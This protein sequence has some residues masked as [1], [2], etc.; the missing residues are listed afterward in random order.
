MRKLFLLSLMLGGVLAQAA[1]ISQP[2]ALELA[3]NFINQNTARRMMS[4][5]GSSSQLSLAHTAIDMTGNVDIYIFNRSNEGGFILVAGDDQLEPVLGFSDRGSFDANNMPDGLRYWL[6]EYQRQMEYL[7]ANPDKVAPRKASS[8]KRNAA[9]LLSTCWNQSE[10]YNNMCPTYTSEGETYHSVTG[11]VATAAAQIMK[12]WK[13]P[14][15]GKGS[16]VYSCNVNNSGESLLSAVFSKSTYRWDLMDNVY[17][18]NS[19]SSHNDAVALLMRD[20]GYAS[21]MKYGSSSGTSNDKIVNA[22]VN[23]FGYDSGI[24]LEIRDYYGV[25]AWEQMIIDEIDASRPVYYSGSSSKG[26][27]AFVVDGY[28]T[29]GYF[30]INWGWGGSSDGYF[31]TS[32][33]NPKDQGIGSFEGGYN[34][35]QAIIINIKPDEGGKPLVRPLTGVCRI[36]PLLESVPL[37]TQAQFYVSNVGI[38]GSKEWNNYLYWG[39]A[40]TK[41]VMS[42]TT[43]DI[44]QEPDTWANGTNV[45]IGVPGYEWSTYIIPSKSLAEG[46]YYLRLINSIDGTKTGFFTGRSPNDYIVEMEV[47]DGRA[48]FSNYNQPV[49][50]S[51]LNTSVSSARIYAERNFEVTTTLANLGSEYYGNVYV[52]MKKNAKTATISEPVQVAI[53]AGGKRTFKTQ[54]TAPATTGVYDLT[55]LDYNK[56]I[57]GIATVGVTSNGGDPSLTIVEDLKPAASVMPANDV[58][59]SITVKNNGGVY[60]G[61]MEMRVIHSSGTGA[62][63]L[64][65]SDFLTIKG[66]ETCTVN[67]KGEIP[68]IVGDTYKMAVY[69]PLSD[70]TLWSSYKTFVVG[71]NPTAGDVNGDGIID[72]SDLNIVL[73]IMQGKDSASNYNGRADLSGDGIIDVTDMNEII[74]LILQNG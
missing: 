9:P 6:G 54:L 67:F 16:I 20:L 46:K 48:Y 33:L 1:S 15:C 22:L 28:N 44:V 60:T 37:G 23:N 43:S 27:H 66:G 26:G 34:N 10:P 2:Q 71:E 35:Y 8:F 19:L 12:Y 7:K 45:A 63:R 3:Q 72:I 68:G 4:H 13:Y 61:N 31:I 18:S 25:E 50:L 59:A 52:A 5:S 70:N 65:S 57:I 49:K 56:S 24:H 55:L 51:L 69:R 42:P 36:E 14:A 39:L 17:T 47:K 11:C 38:L 53:P 74:N 64:I 58:R 62:K 29:D 21:Q 73:D 40:A 32:I 30:H 41:T